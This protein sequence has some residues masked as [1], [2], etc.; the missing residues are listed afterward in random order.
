MTQTYIDL[1]S[2]LRNIDTDYCQL[3]SYRKVLIPDENM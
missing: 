3:A 1:D 2:L